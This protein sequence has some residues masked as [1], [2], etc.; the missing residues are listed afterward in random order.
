MYKSEIDDMQPCITRLLNTKPVLIPQFLGNIGQNIPFV[1][2][3]EEK[4]KCVYGIAISESFFKRGNGTFFHGLF[5]HGQFSG[6][7]LSFHWQPFR[8]TVTEGLF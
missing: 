7:H 1:F 5:N 8:I 6:Q 4:E 3:G 2:Y